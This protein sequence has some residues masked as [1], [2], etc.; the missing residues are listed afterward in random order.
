MW[1]WHIFCISGI[2]RFHFFGRLRG[3][4]RVKFS[5]MGMIEECGGGTFFVSRAF[6]VSVFWEI[7]GSA[8]GK[9]FVYGINEHDASYIIELIWIIGSIWLEGG[10]VS[11]LS[12]WCFGKWHDYL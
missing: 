11:D 3:Q 8:Q 6:F 10:Y 7:A 12:N 1:R 4:I 9:V 5:Y 2:F